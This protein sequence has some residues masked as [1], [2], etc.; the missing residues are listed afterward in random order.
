MVAYLLSHWIGIAWTNTSPNVE[1]VWDKA[2]GIGY[3]H[4]SLVLP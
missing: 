3:W 1:V 2:F 4:Y